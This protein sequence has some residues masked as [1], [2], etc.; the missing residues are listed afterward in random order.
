MTEENDGHGES[1]S[2][3]AG[4]GGGTVAADIQTSAAKSGQIPK[5]LASE[6]SLQARRTR[7]VRSER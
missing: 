4:E 7:K 5:P 6:H 1:L 3:D 2:K